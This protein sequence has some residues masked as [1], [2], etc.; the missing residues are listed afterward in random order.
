VNAETGRHT[1]TGLSTSRF[2]PSSPR[3]CGLHIGLR[4]EPSLEK[5][6]AWI[7]RAADDPQMR[8]YA[9]LRR[10]QHVGNVIFDRLDSHLAS[11]RMSMYIGEPSDRGAGVGTVALRLA[12]AEVFESLSLHKVWLT[13]HVKNVR[14]IRVYLKFGFVME[15]S[16]EM[17]FVCG[18]G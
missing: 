8:A 11:A 1:R 14:A 6:Q 2:P 3:W 5:T 18:I 7:R 12:L 17:S 9:I 15:G 4:S 13:V 10:D 16:C